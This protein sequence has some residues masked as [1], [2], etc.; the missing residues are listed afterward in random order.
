M[1]HGRG[2]NVN[3]LNELWFYSLR[4]E[5]QRGD[6]W[7]SKDR[8]RLCEAPGN[9][10]HKVLE[11]CS[12]R[13][14]SRG[15]GLDLEPKVTSRVNG[16]REEPS[17]L[18]EE[19]Q[20]VFFEVN[21]VWIETGRGSQRRCAILNFLVSLERDCLG[22]DGEDVSIEDVDATRDGIR[23]VALLFFMV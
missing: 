11:R 12:I 20:N 17:L 6:V 10:L 15:P 8:R 13:W 3:G 14:E 16:A 5:R 19:R 4:S 23:D 9:R 18:N 21:Q 1:D 2:M 22:E 7:G